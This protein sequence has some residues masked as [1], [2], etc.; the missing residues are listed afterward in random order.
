M[1]QLFFGNALLY[2]L[3]DVIHFLADKNVSYQGLSVHASVLSVFPKQ[4]GDYP[5]NTIPYTQYSTYYV[6]T[7]EVLL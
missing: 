1:Q 3:S 2:N 6:N 4:L 7:K 5:L